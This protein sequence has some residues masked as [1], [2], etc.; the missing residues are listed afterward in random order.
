MNLARRAAP[1]L[2]LAAALGPGPLPPARAWDAAG[3]MAVAALA[4]DRLTP[5]ARAAVDA[6]LARHPDYAAWTA[7]VLT[8]RRGRVAFERAATWPDD[9]RRTPDDRPLWHYEDLPVLA[10]GY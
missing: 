8:G 5:R 2:G 3:H 10:P 1:L 6:L 4:Y 9:V 7:G